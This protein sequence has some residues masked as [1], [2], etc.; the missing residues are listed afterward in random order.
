MS[1]DHNS[2][3]M[4]EWIKDMCGLGICIWLIGYLTSIVLF[5]SPYASMMGWIITPVFTPITIA[6]A[7]WW[8]R[9]R[10]LVLTYF[11]IV[12]VAWTLIAVVLDYLFIVQLFQSTYY[13]LDVFLYYILTFLIPVGVGYYL[14]VLKGKGAEV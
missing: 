12:G 4:K 13:S 1:E 14:T 6:I 5:F 7:W 2:W 8:F 9:M 11:I 10:N 3:I